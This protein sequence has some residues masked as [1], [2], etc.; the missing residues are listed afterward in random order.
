M[1]PT[2]LPALEIRLGGA[3]L[4]ADALASL[5]EVCIRQALSVPSQCELVLADPR[6]SLARE[7]VALGTRLEIRA[8]QA[9]EP[10]F[11]GDVTAVELSCGP[12][13]DLRLRVRAY[14]A[15]HHLRE[16]QPVRAHA[17]LGALELA[18]ELAGELGLEVESS[19]AAPPW[20]HRV[21]HRQTD[22]EMLV[23]LAA[24]SGLY[25]ALRVRTLHLATLEGLGAP[26]PLAYG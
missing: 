20:R 19:A 2:G 22:L 11:E 7:G 1:K 17:G 24:R 10:L 6:G 26:L 15:L 4:S 3:P 23:E 21:Q 25:L 14:D 13:R 8:G 18:R 12:R 16:R 5:E 9:E